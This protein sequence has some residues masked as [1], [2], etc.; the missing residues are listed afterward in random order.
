[1]TERGIIKR[2]EFKNQVADMNGLC[3]GKITPT[4]LDAFIDFG[5]KLFVFIEAKYGDSKM[6]YGQRLALQRLCDACHKPPMRYAVLFLTSHETKGDID[7]SK[8]RITEYR[9]NGKWKAPQVL[10]STLL[11]GVNHFRSFCLQTAK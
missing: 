8:T 9:Y 1:M 4:D 7:F 5:N 6:P 11:D 2:R 10:D 3:F